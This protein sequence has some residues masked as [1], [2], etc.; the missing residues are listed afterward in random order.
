MSKL[1]DR[2]TLFA[3]LSVVAGVV[4]LA[5]EMRQNTEAIRAQTRDSITEKQMEFSGWIATNRDLADVLVRGNE[6][7]DELQDA[8]R[9]MFDFAIHGIM[10][11]WENSLY[12]FNRGLFSPAEFEARRERWRL[13]MQM[14]GYQALWQ[15]TRATFAPEFRA[16]IDALVAVATG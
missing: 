10:R 2:L 6:G 1:N 8:D 5:V 7:Y 12:Q 3:N 16:E 4:F 13:N 11:E 15:V 9:I 14:P